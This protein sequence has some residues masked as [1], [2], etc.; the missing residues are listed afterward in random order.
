M[1]LE[2]FRR[3]RIHISVLVAQTSIWA[4]PEA[5]H[6]LL[7]NTGGVAVYPNSRRYKPGRGESRGQIENG[8]RL[9]DNTYANTAIKRAIGGRDKVDGFE[10]C[11]IWPGTCY[12]P[13]YHTALANLVL[14][15]RALAGLSDHDPETRDCLQYHSFKLY[16][17]HPSGTKEPKRPR[18]SS[19]K[20]KSPEKF[21]GSIKHQ[22]EKTTHHK[23][24]SQDEMTP[25]ERTLIHNRVEKWSQNTNLLVHNIIKFVI[26]AGNGISRQQ[27][28]GK[29]AKH[30]LLKIHEALSLVFLQANLRRM[31]VSLF[32]LV[33][34]KF[35]LK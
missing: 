24:G 17:W 25:I 35:I 19:A 10:A 30:L 2:A 22:A 9:D 32:L 13:R 4:N 15:P 23:R 21:G 31:A 33:G 8:I 3:N 28:E 11:H 5:H 27:L 26:A 20:W 7:Q 6:R 14:L 29:V 1:L 12:D 18:F 34:N 16:G